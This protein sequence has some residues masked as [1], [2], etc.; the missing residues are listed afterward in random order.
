MTTTDGV[1]K[2]KLAMDSTKATIA[3]QDTIEL[4]YEDEYYDSDEDE[5]E[6]IKLNKTHHQNLAHR[7]RCFSLKAFW[8]AYNQ[9]LKDFDLADDELCK[10][11]A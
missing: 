10:L 3:S 7:Y 1:S 5:D 6:T 2:N 9:S 11:I 4:E 8:N